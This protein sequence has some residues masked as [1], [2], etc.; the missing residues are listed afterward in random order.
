MDSVNGRSYLGVPK[1]TLRRHDLLEGLTEPSGAV[2]L[3]ITVEGREGYTSKPPRE[4]GAPGGLQE[5]PVRAAGVLPYVALQ[6]ALGSPSNAVWQHVWTGQPGKPAQ[7]PSGV[8]TGGRSCRCGWLPLRW[9]L[10]FSPVTRGQLI[11]CGPRP[12]VNKA[13]LSSR[14]GR[15]RAELFS[16]KYSVQTTQTR[17]GP[18]FSHSFGGERVLRTFLGEVRELRR[19]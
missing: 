1:T 17:L 5:A 14:G 9:A 16:K 19:R 7:R 6:A 13:L 15:S 2:I 18:P 8:C 12:Q 3:A 11:L 4:Q 10:V